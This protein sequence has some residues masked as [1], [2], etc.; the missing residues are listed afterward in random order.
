M[1]VI[2]EPDD[3]AEN[4]MMARALEANGL[5]VLVEIEQIADVQTQFRL[6]LTKLMTDA[7]FKHKYD[8]AWVMEVVNQ[9]ADELRCISIVL[10][11]MWIMLHRVLA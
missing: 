8:Y 3:S 6:T 11:I 1:R 5:A 4:R 9:H 2:I 10:K 7:V